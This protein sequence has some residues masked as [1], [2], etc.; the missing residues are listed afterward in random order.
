M[1]DSENIRPIQ[2]TLRERH[3]IVNL[4][5]V[6]PD[7]VEKFQL[8]ILKGQ[9]LVV[10]LSASDMDVLLGAIAADAN[11]TEQRKLQKELDQLF[12][13]LDDVSASEFPED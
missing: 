5:S 7:I 13:R 3:L 8:A 11:H 9:T 4:L 6:E 1:I 2:F 10:S 12:V